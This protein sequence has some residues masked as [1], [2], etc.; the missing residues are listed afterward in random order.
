MREKKI[1]GINSCNKSEGVRGG[2]AAAAAAAMHLEG[3]VEGGRRPAR[4][5]QPGHNGSLG[6]MAPVIFAV[7]GQ[8][9]KL[10][11]DWTGGEGSGE[12][13]GAR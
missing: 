5:H 9:M 3:G 10:R 7:L 12:E 11:S 1:L 13:R 8:P 6:K 2:A 4:P